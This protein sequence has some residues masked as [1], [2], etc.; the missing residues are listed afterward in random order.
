MSQ[1]LLEGVVH[2][3]P[4]LGLL[5]L[6]TSVVLPV[7]SASVQSVFALPLS[8]DVL[9]S[10]QSSGTAG[11]TVSH[12]LERLLRGAFADELLLVAAPRRQDGEAG[13]GQDQA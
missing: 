12:M 7:S 11:A 3:L 5:T 1:S 6:T 9:V 8:A 2:V 4:D 13:E 10:P